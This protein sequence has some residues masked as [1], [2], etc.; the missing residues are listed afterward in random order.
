M[1]SIVF[2]ISVVLSLLLLP[3]FTLGVGNVY[4]SGVDYTQLN[5]TIQ[6]TPY[7]T[8]MDN[9]YTQGSWEAYS[10]VMLA[11]RELL[12]KDGATQQEVDDMAVLLQS[13]A[14]ALVSVVELRNQINLSVELI[15]NANEYS[16]ITFDN[17]SVAYTNAVN[18]LA[19]YS[20]TQNL[21]NNASGTLEYT[22]ANLLNINRYK[23]V[24]QRVPSDLSK[25]TTESVNVLNERLALVQSALNSTNT[26]QSVFDNMVYSL[27]ASIAGLKYLADKNVLVELK[28]ELLEL[29]KEDYTASSRNK[30]DTAINEIDT[31][32]A[33]TELT[34]V[35]MNK[36]IKKYANLQ[37]EL[38]VIKELRAVIKENK[39]YSVNDYA[40]T[41]YNNYYIALKNAKGCVNNANATKDEVSSCM[42][43][44]IK[45][46]EEL[47]PLATK[48]Q[49]LESITT[50][51]NLKDA[52]ISTDSKTKLNVCIQDS[53]LVYDDIESSADLVSQT[54]LIVNNVIQ[55]VIQDEQ[56]ILEAKE[57]LQK[58]MDYILSLNPKNYAY[59]SWYNLQE[60]YTLAFN[61]MNSTDNSLLVVEET[62]NN[63]K[64][65]TNGLRT[66]QE[67][68]FSTPFKIALSCVIIFS[69]SL[70]IAL[71]RMM[72]LIKKGKFK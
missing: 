65:S 10:P 71:I 39:N 5:A 9:R 56:E 31:T 42:V 61:V 66:V 64:K 38:V 69:I 53:M 6:S 57:T 59:F 52:E 43:N 8:N 7:C 62:I 47:L 30:I 14:N 51:I 49:L 24:V 60:Q 40:P 28:D 36:V 34:Q 50:A 27:D 12:T 25:Y 70:G 26:A 19:Q 4:A 20:P 15:A 58:L 63:L 23:L 22:R 48:E 17:F 11:A 33:I 55:V 72:Y 46:V 41:S 21:V 3:V 54:T 45:S 2:R 67:D 1:R 29:N 37:E 13:R 16:V 68:K 44:L 18:V 35:D 32:L